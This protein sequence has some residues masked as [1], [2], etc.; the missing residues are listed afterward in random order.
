MAELQLPQGDDWDLNLYEV[1]DPATVPEGSMLSGK[2]LSEEQRSLL[3]AAVDDMEQGCN[4]LMDNLGIEGKRRPFKV[5]ELCCEA[6]RGISTQ[7]EAMGGIGIRCGL[8]NGC[9][10]QKEAGVQKV[11]QLLEKEKPDLLWV[12]CPC[13]PTSAIQELN[14]L[15]E[16]G[17]EKIR[18]KVLKSKKLVGNGIRVMEKQVQLGGE[19]FKN[20]LPTTGPGASRASEPSGTASTRSR[21]SLKLA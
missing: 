4:L 19:V 18:K 10:L 15:T 1:E 14:M 2:Q 6:D 12:S 7:V 21:Q 5:M 17:R 3:H 16:E 13:G 8:H 20:G 9:D 11:L